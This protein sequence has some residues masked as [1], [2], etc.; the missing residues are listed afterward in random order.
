MPNSEMADVVGRSISCDQSREVLVDGTMAR[1]RSIVRLVPDS[2][3]DAEWLLRA[4]DSPLEE[5]SRALDS[6]EGKP[7][8]RAHDVPD[9]LDESD[10]S[11]P[12]SESSKSSSSAN[13]FFRPPPWKKGT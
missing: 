7:D 6:I 2:R 13:F 3:W 4:N 11:D 10:I 9:L 5:S 8:P 1:T 12:S